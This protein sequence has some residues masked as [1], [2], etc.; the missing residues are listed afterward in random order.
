MWS[1]R[2]SNILFSLKSSCYFGFVFCGIVFSCRALEFGWRGAAATYQRAGLLICGFYRHVYD[3]N[4]SLYID[5]VFQSFVWQEDRADGGLEV[6]R[7]RGYAHDVLR[8]GH[9]GIWK[10]N[11]KIQP[12]GQKVLALGFW[13]YGVR[14]CCQAPEE[15]VRKFESRVDELIM[16]VESGRFQD[17]LGAKV[18]GTGLAFSVVC[19]M[20]RGELNVLYSVLHG[21]ELRGME[22]GVSAWW[23]YHFRGTATRRISPLLVQ[24]LLDEL[25]RLKSLVGARR[26]YP[27]RVQRHRSR[28]VFHNDATLTQAGVKIWRVDADGSLV[29]LAEWG[30][31]LPIMVDEDRRLSIASEQMGCAEHMALLQTVR[32]VAHIPELRE[33]FSN[34][35]VD[36]YLDNDGKVVPRG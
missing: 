23:M 34:S 28:I 32:A 11:K 16:L 30:A 4:L 21:R 22:A 13:I 27:F 15:K 36:C 3:A 31:T 8:H 20:V 1:H 29:P 2:Y 10:S 9:F 6:A 26:E 19:P 5:D 25:R 35:A 17:A 24:P 18:A 33:E 12:I 14:Q 7:S